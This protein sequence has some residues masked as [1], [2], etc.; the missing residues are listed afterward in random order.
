MA[1]DY[2]VGRHQAVP[3]GDIRSVS[4][5]DTVLLRSGAEQRSDWARYLD[6]IAA[7]VARGADVRWVR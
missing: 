4:A 3:L 5:G 7:A 1:T 6:A 2:F